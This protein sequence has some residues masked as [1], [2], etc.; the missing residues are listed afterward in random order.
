MIRYLT[1]R[2]VT[3]DLKMLGVTFQSD[4]KFNI[5]IREIL[6][7]ANKC[8]YVI[9]SLRKENYTSIEVD[10]LFN[11]IVMP[12][13]CYAIIQSMVLLSQS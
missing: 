4:N 5:Y 13:R 2:S 3:T 8:L 9:R 11:T 12:K 1:Y 10:Y 7:S 6:T